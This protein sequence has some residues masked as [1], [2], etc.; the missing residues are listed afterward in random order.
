MMIDVTTLI[1]RRRITVVDRRPGATDSAPQSLREFRMTRTTRRLA[2]L[3]LLPLLLLPATLPPRAAAQFAAR[4]SLDS[5]ALRALKKALDEG[6]AG[7]LEDFWREVGRRGAPLVEPIEGDGENVLVTF[8]WRAPAG[9]RYVAVFPFARPN[10]L[11][12]LLVNMPGTDLWYRSYPLRRD[13]RFEYAFSV[14]D[15]LAPFAAEQPGEPG[16]WLASTLPDPLNPRR[17]VEPKDPESASSEEESSSFLE[18]PGAPPQPYVAPRAGV[19]K[20]KLELI[21]YEGRAFK[22]ARRVWVYTPPSYERGGGPYPLLLLFDGWEYTRRIPTPTILDNMIADGATPPLIAVFVE[23]ADRFKELALNPHFADFVA[24]EL[25]PWVRTK[26]RVTDDARRRIVG[27]LSLGGL[28]AAYTAARHPEVFGNVLS[29]SGSFQLGAD[30]ERGLIRRMAK[31]RRVR[32]RFYLEAG[33]LEVGDSPS[34][35]HSNR[36]LRDVLTA[37][38]YEVTYSEFNGRHDV[39]CWRGSLSQGI[40]SLTRRPAK[41]RA[42]PGLNSEVR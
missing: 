18:L 10:P 38:G 4:Q 22:G 3:A 30:D 6:R 2:A 11:R 42:A 7:A 37:K 23:H 21:R 14:N 40:V 9:E 35:L 20:G 39:V 15:S 31:G 28:A 19:A 41:G 34:L 26:Y 32:V 36:H 1:S 17:I 27:G 8:L 25:V 5:P 12:G 33:L 13:A 29:Q 16:G 24:G